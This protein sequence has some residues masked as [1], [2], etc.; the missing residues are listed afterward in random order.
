[1]EAGMQITDP[2]N[3]FR[4]LGRCGVSSPHAESI[5]EVSRMLRRRFT[6]DHIS[7][8]AELV[9]DYPGAEGFLFVLK[10]SSL[11]E[12]VILPVPYGSASRD[13]VLKNYSDKLYFR[14]DLT[15]PVRVGRSLEDLQKDYPLLSLL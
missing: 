11:D 10:N 3:F 7:Y 9:P 14:R 13:F 12:L 8:H 15:F 4:H 5:S 2:E 1:M 6:V